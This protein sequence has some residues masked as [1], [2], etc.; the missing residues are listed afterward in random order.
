MTPVSV[1][2]LTYNEED[3]IEEAVKSVLWADEVVVFDSFSEDR[4]VEIAEKLGARVVQAPFEGFG[5]LRIDAVAS[6]KNDWIFS[7]DADERCTP[8]AM[9]EIRRIVEAGGPEEAWFVPRRNYFMGKRIKYC[10]WYPDY[11]QPQLFKRG[12]LTYHDDLVHEGYTINSTVG[13]MKN[14]INQIPYKDLSQLVSK[15]ENYSSLGARKMLKDGRRGS[16]AGAFIHGL[17]AFLKVFVFKLGFLDGWAGFIIAFSG[18]EATFYRYA[19]LVEI[20]EK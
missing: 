1:Y 6:T 2:I 18:F 7:L 16:M 4:T 15:M 14:S 5:K 13:Y 3:K 19:K 9:E 8:E 12:A 17:A 11:R 20:Q 10:G